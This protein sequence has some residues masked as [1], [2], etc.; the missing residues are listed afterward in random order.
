MRRD[1]ELYLLNRATGSGSAGRCRMPPAAV[2]RTADTSK[3]TLTPKRRLACQYP[4]IGEGL[5]NFC[6]AQAPIEPHGA[7]AVRSRR[8][9]FVLQPGQIE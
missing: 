8:E 6:R 5:P 2:R 7:G 4:I 3:A 9:L 1:I